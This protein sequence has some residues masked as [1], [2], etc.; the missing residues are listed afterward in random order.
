ME[1]PTDRGNIKLFI[2]KQCDYRVECLELMR[3]SHQVPT[4]RIDIS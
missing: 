4:K 2:C 3:H 1:H